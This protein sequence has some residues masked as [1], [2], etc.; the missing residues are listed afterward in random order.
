[1][2]GPVETTGSATNPLRSRRWR[3]A[4]RADGTRSLRDTF[5]LVTQGQRWS[6]A[7][8]GGSAL[9]GGLA[10]AGVLVV[11]A[12]IAFALANPKKPVELPGG[13]TMSVPALIVVAVALVVVRMGLQL[14]QS[15]RSALLVAN[16]LDRTRRRLMRRY[17]EAS[18]ELQSG[19]RAGRLQELVTTFTEQ[20]SAVM[21]ALTNLL[22]YGLS[23][24]GLV[25][26]ALIV[27]PVAA[28]AVV[29]VG[30]LLAAVLSPFRHLVHGRA[31]EA[32]AR[33]LTYATSVSE[34]AALAQ[35]IHSFGVTT[36]VRIRLEQLSEDARRAWAARVFALA[37]APALYQGA[38]LMVGLGALGV[39][40]AAGSTRLASLGAVVLIMLRSLS[41]AHN[42]QTWMQALHGS[43][44]YVHALQEEEKR[45]MEAS[46]TG[47]GEPC[48]HIDTMAFEH[49]SFEY[50]PGHRALSDISFKAYRGDIIGIVGPSGAGKS[51]LVQLLLRLRDPTDGKV[52]INGREMQHLNLDELHHR[53][54]FVPQDA[55]LFSGTVAENIQFF[56]DGIDTRRVERAAALAN[57][58][59]EARALPNGYATSIGEQGRRLSGGQRQRL[60]IARA[61][62]TSPDVIV[63]DEPTSALDVRSDVLIRNTLAGL[64]K[65]AT[66][67]VIAHRLS[68]LDICSR[69]MVLLDGELQAF[70][71]PMRLERTSPFFRE[72]LELSGLR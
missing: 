32:A 3:S 33:N 29:V 17:L 53:V 7:L 71:T 50:Q 23:L 70:D 6:V 14:A 34:A 63:L 49:V 42:L 16:V 24:V 36:Q 12:R 10:E 55:V 35:E 41:Y 20:T 69:I 59:S 62:A 67:F 45:L 52:M 56:R 51:T 60:C 44:P 1:M 28:L 18:W 5:A 68:T 38:A 30:A 43:V 48:G 40:Y 66:V 21:S 13:L 57:F 4:L 72:A 25:V 27:N 39:V 65:Q 46:L 9:L 61:L 11:I 22:V 54:A 8:V 19:E 15:H 64:G 37:V 26:T 58:D 47:G 2:G 31:R